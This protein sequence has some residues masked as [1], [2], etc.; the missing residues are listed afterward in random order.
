MK[1][2]SKTNDSKY[3][4]RNNSK[5]FFLSGGFLWVF[6]EWGQNRFSSGMF[7]I[8]VGILSEKQTALEFFKVLVGIP[9]TKAVVFDKMFQSIEGNLNVIWKFP[10]LF[11]F[12]NL[13]R[14]EV[15]KS[16]RSI[17]T[18]KRYVL[19]INRYVGTNTYFQ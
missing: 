17:C 19:L 1:Y 8:I 2:Q 3:C 6:L 14:T 16:K 12:Y 7:Q 10:A 13:S 15:S 11:S 5:V 18:L 4:L 9:H